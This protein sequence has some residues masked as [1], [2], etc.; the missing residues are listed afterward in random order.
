MAH[1]MRRQD[2]ARRVWAL[3]E[4]QHGAVSRRQLLELGYTPEAIKYRVRRGRL[5]PKAAGVYAVGRPELSRHGEMMVGVLACGHGAIVSHETAAE[6]WGLRRP[7]RGPLELSIP[8]TSPIARAGMVVHR[9][10]ILVGGAV[11][12]HMRVP[13]AAVPLVLID[14]APRLRDRP[15]ESAVNMAD[16]LDLM[17]PGAIRRSLTRYPRVAGIAR[18]RTL[19]DAHAFRLTDSELERMFQRL[20]R[21]TSLPEPYTQCYASGHRVDFL[22]LDIGL[23]AET[24]SLRYHRTPLQQRRDAARDHAHLLAGRESVR[25]THFQVAYEKPHVESALEEA[26]RRARILSADASGV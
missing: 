7:E 24:D 23:V 12:E 9:R 10:E 13:V 4:R 15:L 26:A 17:D 18:L 22:W 16:S 19:L 11:T 14:M 8:K 21:R 3:A 5:H 1:H 2:R 25:F 6:L 20:V